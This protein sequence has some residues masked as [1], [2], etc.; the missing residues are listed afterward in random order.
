MKPNSPLESIYFISIPE[1]FE[2]SKNAMQIDVT[3]PLPVQK[4][5][6]DAPGQFNPK[7][8][9]PEQILAG[10]LTVLAYDKHN[11]HLQYYRSILTQARPDIKKELSEAAILKV[12]NEDFEIA[13]EIFLALQGLDPEDKAITLITQTFWQEKSRKS[14]IL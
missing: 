10:I 3:I 8:L 5:D 14:G 6:K 12:K 4:K 13:E 9:T 7:E 1:G 2:L 11:E